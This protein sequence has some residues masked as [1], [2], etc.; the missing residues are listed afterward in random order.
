[1]YCA[2]A[3]KE[4]FTHA[5]CGLYKKIK[6]LFHDGIGATAQSAQWDNYPLGEIYLV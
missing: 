1:M 2:V 4:D 3:V 6:L 5:V